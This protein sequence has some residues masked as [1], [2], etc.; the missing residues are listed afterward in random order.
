MTGATEPRDPSDIGSAGQGGG[1]G[2]ASG[3]PTVWATLQAQDAN[4]L[5]IYLTETFGFRLTARYDDGDM[6]AHAELLWPEGAGGLML[7]SYR[8]G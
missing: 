5:I 8:E 7:G 4:A 6:V 3:T 2:Q 1:A